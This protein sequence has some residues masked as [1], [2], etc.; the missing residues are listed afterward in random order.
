MQ[1]KFTSYVLACPNLASTKVV[2]KKILI[3]SGNQLLCFPRLFCYVMFFTSVTVLSV[4]SNGINEAGYW[5]CWPFACRKNVLSLWMLGKNEIF[6]IQTCLEPETHL[7]FRHK[8]LQ[9][10]TKNPQLQAEKPATTGNSTQNFRQ[11]AIRPRVNSRA[12]CR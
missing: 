7:L 4:L 6:E 3:F 1:F 2:I 5:T 12:H 10:H 11:S 8:Y 9:L